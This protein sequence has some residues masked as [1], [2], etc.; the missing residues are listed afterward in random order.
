MND[1]L[2]NIVIDSGSCYTKSGYNGENAPRSVIPTL[3]GTY[4]N[5][6]IMLTEDTKKFIGRE[7]L[8]N[9]I[10]NVSSPIKN[11]KIQNWDEM[12][13]I[14]EYIFTSELKTSSDAH[15]IFLL[16][17]LYSSNEDK[18]KAA[19]IIFEKFNAFNFHI[20]PQP[21][22]TLYSTTKTTGLIV[23]SGAGTTQIVP[24]Y[25]G[26][27]ISNS[28]Q[29]SEIGGESITNYIRNKISDRLKRYKVYNEFEI[30]R[31]IKE[32]LSLTSLTPLTGTENLNIQKSYELPDGN[33]INIGDEVMF[34]SE[35]NF[36]PEFIG[37]D[38]KGIDELIINCIDSMEVNI[39]KDFYSNIV[40][41]GG[42]C[43]IV[44]LSERLK[45]ELTGKIN[46]TLRGGLRINAQPE[47]KY[48]AWIGASVMCSIS[49]FQQMWTSKS[50]YEETGYLINQ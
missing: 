23:E 48:S 41:G 18:E 39:K 29:Y 34:A 24:I 3:Y 21:I 26:Y 15:H 25:E 19:Q 43:S 33:T 31:S 49:S 46:S 30:S 5:Q 9:C 44:N 35:G 14:W 20:E 16:M 12:E 2:S 17:S 38:S 22:M 45:K 27:I 10:L 4:L 11:G 1:Y 40:L 47:R 8:S 42:N 37:L 50:E 6:N 36:N 28:I 32:Q 7:C 13:A